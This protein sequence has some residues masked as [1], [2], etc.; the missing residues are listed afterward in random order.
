MEDLGSCYMLRDYLALPLDFDRYVVFLVMINLIN[1]NIRVN[2]IIDFKIPKII[3]QTLRAFPLISIILRYTSKVILNCFGV[4]YLT[5]QKK[6]PM[7]I[8]SV[9]SPISSVSV[10]KA[11]SCCGLRCPTPPKRFGWQPP[12][13][14]MCSCWRFAQVSLHLIF[15]KQKN[16]WR[17]H[18]NL[19]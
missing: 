3:K 17:K 16:I 15:I 6:H 13:H 7:K 8:T 10:G 4:N 11:Q 18:S 19:S 14:R 5:P 12:L 1:P 9:K 2:V